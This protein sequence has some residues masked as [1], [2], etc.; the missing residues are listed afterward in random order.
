MKMHKYTHLIR[1]ENLIKGVKDV[2][3]FDK[4]RSGMYTVEYIQQ[5]GEV[6]LIPMKT[7]HDD[8]MRLP[9]TEFDAIE[10]K[11]EM[12]LTEDCKARFKKRGYM[13]KISWLLHGRPGTGKTCIVNRLSQMVMEKNGIVL[14]N[15]D[16]RFIEGVYALLEQTNPDSLVL[17]VF[18]EMDETLRRHEGELLN[19]LDGEV[20]RDKTMFVATTNFIDRIPKRI[21]R[22]RRFSS[23]VEV[24]EPSK[25]ARSAYIKQKLSD[26][27]NV[28]HLIEATDGLT[29][30]EIGE[31]VR[32]V[33]CL[34]EDLD[35]T[36]ARIKHT[37]SL[38]KD[39]AERKNAFVEAIKEMTKKMGARED[40]AEESEPSYDE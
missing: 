37:L 13:Y 18:E 6:A 22:P 24:K 31:V 21:L 3:V 11:M 29:I 26:Y 36:V 33:D 27:K 25:A 40:K 2:E 17:I 19:V 28:S 23:V 30:D 20:Q 7:T 5:T 12:F 38:G 8:L 1:I 4:L 15:P 35:E 16:P 14:F 39:Q 32:S 9:D 34:G 10:R